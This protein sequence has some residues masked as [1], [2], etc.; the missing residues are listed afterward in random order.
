[1]RFGKVILDLEACADEEQDQSGLSKREE[2]P[3]AFA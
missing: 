2:L 1:L 3:E